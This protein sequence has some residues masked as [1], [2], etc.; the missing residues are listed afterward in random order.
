MNYSTITQSSALSSDLVANTWSRP[1]VPVGAVAVSPH[2][3]VPA[4]WF[5]A[6]ASTS[7][8]VDQQHMEDASAISF[9]GDTPV[10]DILAEYPDFET[11][12]PSET[13][14]PEAPNA[15]RH[16]ASL[17]RD[18]EK[19]KT[20]AS[21]KHHSK[22]RKFHQRKHRNE[23]KYVPPVERSPEFFEA[24]RELCASHKAARLEAWRR[25]SLRLS[26]TQKRI[27]QI[28]RLEAM[29][30]KDRQAKSIIEEA[31]Y[32]E[33]KY[34]EQLREA[35]RYLS[36]SD[37]NKTAK[38]TV[39]KEEARLRFAQDASFESRI[40]S[41]RSSDLD[42]E[43]GLLRLQEKS[44]EKANLEKEMLQH[45]IRPHVDLLHSPNKYEG[46]QCYAD[47]IQFENELK[48][49][50]WKRYQ[51]TVPDKFK[52]I[53]S[54]KRKVIKVVESREQKEFE[55]Y[56][57]SKSEAS[58]PCDLHTSHFK[59]VVYNSNPIATEESVEAVDL[60][61]AVFCPFIESSSSDNKSKLRLPELNTHN[62]IEWRKK[63]AI[64]L[65]ADNPN[66]TTVLQYD[67]PRWYSSEEETRIRTLLQ[68]VVPPNI[69]VANLHEAV[70]DPLY[71]RAPA[72]AAYN[73]INFDEREEKY[74]FYNCKLHGLIE[75]AC[76]GSIQAQV[77]LEKRLD[78][79]QAAGGDLTKLNGKGL[80]EAIVELFNRDTIRT[81]GEKLKTFYTR[82]MSDYKRGMDLVTTLE[83]DSIE[84]VRLGEF[85]L[86]SVEPKLIDRFIDAIND[87]PRYLGL[88]GH[89]RSQREDVLNGLTWTKVKS[90]VK[91]DDIDRDSDRMRKAKRSRDHREHDHNSPVKK[92]SGGYSKVC[93]SCGKKGHVA[94]ECRSKPKAMPATKAPNK[95]GPSNNKY[96][97]SSDQPKPAIRCYKCGGPHY[98]NKCG[99]TRK[100]TAGAHSCTDMPRE[101]Y[102]ADNTDDVVAAVCIFEDADEASHDEVTNE[103]RSKFGEDFASA[104]VD[105]DEDS[106]DEDSFEGNSHWQ[107]SSAYDAYA[108]ELSNYRLYHEQAER[109]ERIK[110]KLII[111]RRTI[112][113]VSHR[114][115]SPSVFVDNDLLPIRWQLR[116]LSSLSPEHPLIGMPL[117]HIIAKINMIGQFKE[118]YVPI[119]YDDINDGD[120]DLNDD[121]DDVDDDQ[122]GMPKRMRASADVI[123]KRHSQR[124]Y[125][126]DDDDE[127]FGSTCSHSDIKDDGWEVQGTSLR[128]H[129]LDF[130]KIDNNKTLFTGVAKVAFAAHR[131][132]P[133]AV[134]LLDSGAS[135]CMFK[136]RSMFDYLKSTDYGI[137]TASSSLTVKEAGPVKCI[138]EAYYLPTATHDL[139][140]LGDLDHLGCKVVIEG[141][142]LT[143]YRNDEEIIS[144]QKSN[145]V[146]TTYT[147]ELLDG[148]LSAMSA[149]E[150]STMWWLP[151]A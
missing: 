9:Y 34:P 58:S 129:E 104:Q 79:F 114:D 102:R 151:K 30:R 82:T 16:P 8:E 7:A 45:W 71:R 111:L 13:V 91:K 81:K 60:Y 145:N 59:N 41:L 31:E 124:D 98:T 112:T 135:K 115:F 105:E 55:R 64:E 83:K 42:H 65:R 92:P 72:T 116:Y 5:T 54:N 125:D 139:I 32:A 43:L 74:H 96:G 117:D 61:E 136:D 133:R 130:I 110:E 119:D 144:I 27:V 138:A 56:Q 126:D 11:Q 131:D 101:Y 20:H 141:G 6:A 122:H 4:S 17:R 107:A 57:R 89:L 67:R 14:D 40:A 78:D 127:H 22:G 73:A 3:L 94:S 66:Y 93:H 121:N 149:E 68:P 33:L 87:E 53:M 120:D 21:D 35:L 77:F 106:S 12:D 29:L 10:D 88:V 24:Q 18:V 140:S 84:L 146:W 76:I 85:S 142:L 134:S 19:A 123:S 69:A 148:I 150:K 97:P 49:A 25:K 15:S 50:V 62:V 100:V 46:M 86:D 26:D 1:L 128:N 2:F 147:A 75:K 103:L 143:V 37:S 63:V 137:S 28:Q 47:T 48:D 36:T 90:I 99:L 113:D 108:D 132:S 80:L 70:T 118:R 52:P 44:K 38:A 39:T 23:R 109:L 51:R 95:Y